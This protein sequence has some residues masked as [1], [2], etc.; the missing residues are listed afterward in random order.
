MDFDFLPATIEEG[1]H[2]GHGALIIRSTVLP[3][4]VSIIFFSKVLSPKPG[5]LKNYFL[6]LEKTILSVDFSVSNA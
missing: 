4:I 1:C 6:H 5:L 2:S 3:L